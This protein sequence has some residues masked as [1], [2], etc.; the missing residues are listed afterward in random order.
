MYLNNNALLA[1]PGALLQLLARNLKKNPLRIA[2]G[3]RSDLYAAAQYLA[4]AVIALEDEDIA[5]SS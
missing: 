3:V 2:L 4:A 1:A 5:G